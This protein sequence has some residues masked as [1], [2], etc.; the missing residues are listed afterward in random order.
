MLR[1]AGR[2]GP[3][4][5]E[6]RQEIKASPCVTPDET[7]WRVAGQ[8]AWLHAWVGERATGYAIDPHRSADALERLPGIDW[9][10]VL[11][12]DGWSSYDRFLGAI[13]QQCL[14]HVLRRARELLAGATRGAVRYPRQLIALLTEAIHLRNRHRRGEVSARRLGQARAE[15]DRRLRELAWPAR[16]VPAYETLSEHLWKHREEWFT[17][18][19]RPEVEATNWQAEQATRPAVVNRKVW[20]GNRTWAGARAQGVLLSVLETCQRA[21]R[22]GLEFV[23]QTLRAF[24]NP[25]LP[26]PVLLAPR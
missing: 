1:A 14:G 18:L 15:F 11:A 20:G 2:L 23:S 5:Q 12:H 13:H 4:H 17:F 8:P 25:L 6:V 22:S 3:A 19:S 26:R 16:E 9:A 10:G 21:G 7:G 24:G